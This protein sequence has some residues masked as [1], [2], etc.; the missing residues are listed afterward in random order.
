MFGVV[1]A[2]QDVESRI[3]ACGLGIVYDF[4]VLGRRFWV[5]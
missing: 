3:S 1:G 4:G 5:P 2:P